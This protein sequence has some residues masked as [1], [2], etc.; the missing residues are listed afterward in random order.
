MEVIITLPT[1]EYINEMAMTFCAS[2][3]MYRLQ[4]G[5]EDIN[6]Y[7]EGVRSEIVSIASILARYLPL[8]EDPVMQVIIASHAG[9]GLSEDA[10]PKKSKRLT[11]NEEARQEAYCLD[12]AIAAMAEY[13]QGG[14]KTRASFHKHKESH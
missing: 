14:I 9:A 2:V 6:Q 7:D 8:I 13:T 4:S 1:S 3:I 10:P 11:A 12:P 5:I